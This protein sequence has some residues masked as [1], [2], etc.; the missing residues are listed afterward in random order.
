MAVPC[1]LCT[2]GACDASSLRRYD[3]AH[4]LFASSLAAFASTTLKNFK[5]LLVL[6]LITPA[7]LRVPEPVPSSPIRWATAIDFTTSLP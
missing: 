6:V 4:D 7:I 2:D 5:T 1:V 3:D